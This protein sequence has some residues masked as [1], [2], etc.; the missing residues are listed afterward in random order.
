M[1]PDAA[2]PDTALT[3]PALHEAKRA[4]RAR[5]ID[6]RDALDPALRESASRA[7]AARLQAL[8]SFAAAHAVLLTLPFRSEWDTRPLALATLAAGKTLVAPS[9]NGTT[10][11][12][13]LHA[14]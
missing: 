5:M 11:M 4:L 7:I 8:P 10:R 1:L 3:G 13:E 12:L 2:S 9:I 6:V 14:I